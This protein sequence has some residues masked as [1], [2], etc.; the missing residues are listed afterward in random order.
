M[1]RIEEIENNI[2]IRENYSIKLIDI[3]TENSRWTIKSSTLFKSENA[4]INKLMFKKILKIFKDEHTETKD[5]KFHMIDEYNNIDKLKK[6]KE[7]T[8]L[9]LKHLIEQNKALGLSNE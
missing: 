3:N 4:K 8:E 2:L 9:R 7:N 1:K 5:K 6:E